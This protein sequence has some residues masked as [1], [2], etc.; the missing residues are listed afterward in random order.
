MKLHQI[1]PFRQVFADPDVFLDLL[2]RS[3]PNQGHM[4]EWVGKHKI[5]HI[6]PT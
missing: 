2:R 6:Q 5:Q 4:D 3:H 1:D